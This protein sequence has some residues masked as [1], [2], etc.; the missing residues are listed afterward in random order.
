MRILVTGGYGFV[1]RAAA[2][3]LRSAGHDV[4]ITTRRHEAQSNPGSG[5]DVI[6]GCDLSDPSFTTALPQSVDA[7]VHCAGCA[8][9]RESD[10]R[11]HL[12]DNVAATRNITRWAE[13]VRASRLVF[14]STIG[15]HDRPWGH[16]SRG[17]ISE[18]SERAASSA[19]GRSKCLAEDLV[20]G[21]SV[22]STI[23][24]L[25]WVYGQSMR[26][27]SHIRALTRISSRHRFISRVPLPG[28][29]SV[30]DVRDVA[31]ATR[32]VIERS[33][34]MPKTDVILMS[35]HHP[36]PLRRLLDPD[37]RE[38]DGHAPGGIRRGTAAVLPFSLRVLVD[39]AL[40]ADPARMEARGLGGSHHFAEEYPRL[41]AIKDWRL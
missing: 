6:A 10:W 13:R 31:N 1:G 5:W 8:E 41:L 9:F 14:M 33:A 12:R 39:D 11:R 16:P 24:R 20:I 32:L 38:F 18:C 30:I 17:R 37:G 35:E 3:E 36:I 29:V 21:A 2:S 19:Y 28:R 26:R 40:V 15:V 7:V 23:L 4:V 27:S 22:P 25:T 34:H